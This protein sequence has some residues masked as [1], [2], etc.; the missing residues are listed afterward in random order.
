M[1]FKTALYN[2]YPTP[3]ANSAEVEK[4]EKYQGS[5][6]DLMPETNFKYKGRF[7][8]I[9]MQWPQEKHKWQ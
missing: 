9:K 8:K 1:T 3:N 5:N 6:M 7:I 2:N 4:P